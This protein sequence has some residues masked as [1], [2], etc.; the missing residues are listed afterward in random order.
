MGLFE[1]KGFEKGTKAIWKAIVEKA[2]HD[3]SAKIII[4][5]G[6]TIASLALLPKSMCLLPENVFLSTGG[7]AMLEF[8]SGKKLPGIEALK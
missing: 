5:G 6:E 4:G 8:L 7:G 3:P 2:I 1:K